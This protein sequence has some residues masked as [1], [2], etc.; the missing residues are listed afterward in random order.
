MLNQ[1]VYNKN[2]DNQLSEYVFASNETHTI[3]E[4]IELAFKQINIV[5]V[6]KNETDDNIN[7]KFYYTNDKNEEIL[8]VKINP[9]FY[10]VAEVDLLFGNSR[11][12]TDELGWVPKTN[13]VQLVEKMVKNDIALLHTKI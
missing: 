12:A 11:K 4:F 5:G 7:E 1:D 3:K 13:F 2:Y 9:A 8:L 6:W 10:R